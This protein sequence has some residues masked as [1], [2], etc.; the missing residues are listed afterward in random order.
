MKLPG[1][2]ESKLKKLFEL[3]KKHKVI[4][5][6]VFGS[7]SKGNFDPN[8]SDLDLIVELDNLN[9]TEKGETLMKLWSELEQLFERKVDLLTNRKIRN[10]YLM[11]EI[12]NSK[13]LLYDRAG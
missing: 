4:R 1:E 8:T 13:L 7:V 10:P 12:E 5:L 3:C 6:F 9:P 11:K 2:I